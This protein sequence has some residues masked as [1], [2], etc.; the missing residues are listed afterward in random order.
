MAVGKHYLVD[1]MPSS[2]LESGIGC[3]LNHPAWRPS[4]RSHCNQATKEDLSQ[5][6]STAPPVVAYGVL[7]RQEQPLGLAKK[8]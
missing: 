4:K 5:S 7:S 3:H 1:P 8:P 6:A 2:N